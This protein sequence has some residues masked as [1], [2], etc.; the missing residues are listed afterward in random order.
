MYNKRV[1]NSS[2]QDMTLSVIFLSVQ[3]LGKALAVPVIVF[4]CSDG[5]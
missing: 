3:D 5:F 2:L 4:N 1:D